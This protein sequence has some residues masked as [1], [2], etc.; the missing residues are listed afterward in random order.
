MDRDDPSLHCW[1]SRRHDFSDR[2]VNQTRDQINYSL[3][4]PFFTWIS[5]FSGRTRNV[6]S[7]LALKASCCVVT[8]TGGMTV[9]GLNF[10][11]AS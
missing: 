4:W 5:N 3:K 8:F 7:D 6:D 2:H 11:N 9:L 10:L 1:N